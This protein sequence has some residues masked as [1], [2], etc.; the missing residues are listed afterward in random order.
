MNDDVN[1]A[2]A[3]SAGPEPMTEAEFKDWQKRFGDQPR[4]FRRERRN[5][6][7]Q[8]VEAPAFL[9]DHYMTGYIHWIVTLSDREADSPH[10]PVGSR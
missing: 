3:Y 10:E 1:S 2:I 6:P 9:E 5:A 8:S 7:I 4:R